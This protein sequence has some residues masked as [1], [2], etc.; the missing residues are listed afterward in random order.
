M[1]IRI[2]IYYLAFSSNSNVTANLWLICSFSMLKFARASS[3]NIDLAYKFA[4]IN[5]HCPDN[6]F[7]G[8]R[9]FML[10][11]FNKCAKYSLRSV[12]LVETET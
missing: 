9:H 12:K 11:L 7:S 1:Q 5:P 2:T 4:A 6:A 3:P 10:V 8:V